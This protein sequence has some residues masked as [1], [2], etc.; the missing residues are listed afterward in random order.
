MKQ[1]PKFD[2]FEFPVFEVITP[3]TNYHLK[4]RSLT[5]AQEEMLKTSAVSTLN[6]ISLINQVVFECI[7]EKP[8]AIATL[9][10]FERGLTVTDR[11]TILYG[12]LIASYGENQKFTIQCPSC[13]NIYDV[14]GSLTDNAEIKLY[15]GKEELLKKNTTI[16]LPISKYKAVLTIPTIRDEKSFTASKGISQDVVKKADSYLICKELQAPSSTTKENGEVDV[17]YFSIDNIFEIYAKM[18]ELPARDRK[19]LTDSWTENYGSYGVTV[20]IPALCPV[21][22]TRTES[23]LSMLGELFRLSR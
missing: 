19:T 20:K 13:G 6:M 11:E 21:C 5:V 22:T 8:E 10:T 18:R 17:K 14:D 2:S 4:V 1:A 7:Q 15:E 9:D 16:T 23:T 3:H 12:M